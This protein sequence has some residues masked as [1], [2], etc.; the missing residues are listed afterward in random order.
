M[1]H[2]FDVGDLVKIVRKAS[3]KEDITNDYV[4]LYGYIDEIVEDENVSLVQ[5]CNTETTLWISNNRLKYI[6]E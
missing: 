6:K 1:I 4:N 2:E 5:I 3:I